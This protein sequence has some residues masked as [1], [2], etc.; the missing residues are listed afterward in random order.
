MEEL[1]EPIWK[2]PEA[3]PRGGGGWGWVDRKGGRHA[4]G[5]VERLAQAIAEDAGARVDMVWTPDS[6]YLVLPE[7]VRELWPALK[8]ARLKWAEWEMMEGMRQMKIFGVFI[9][10]FAIISYLG[11]G[12][13]SVMGT[14]GLAVILFLM[15]GFFPWYQGRKRWKRAK[16]WA[17]DEAEPDLEGLRF[18]VWLMSQ[19]APLTKALA[20]L[21][22]LV[23]L[24]QVLGPLSLAQQVEAAGLLKQDGRALDGWRLGTAAFLHGHP[25]HFLFNI[26]ALLYLGRRMEL[27]ARWPHVLL[28]FLLAAWV[29]NECSAR[30][31][32][33]P[34]L[35]ASG[36]LLGMLGFLLVFEWMHRRLVPESSRRRLLAGLLMTAAL[37][38]VGFK[39]VDNA[40][41]AG[42]TLA[43][44]VYAFAVFPRS[45][46][47]NR[48]RI[49]VVDGVA[50]V[51]AGTVVAGFGLLTIV[52]L[53]G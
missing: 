11:S 10:G 12:G 29:G 35:G 27:L 48:P 43:G 3:F 14:F 46:S 31:L 7:E 9:A 5:D 19:R 2:R 53:L 21:I 25:L 18:E 1:D 47:A 39:F 30:W 34:S 13:A 37:G 42:G 49:S 24:V 52:K 8:M 22:A 40:A 28:V 26:S 41:H 6:P 51:L 44:M 17:A 16:A 15:L 45:Q 20:G 36:G 23:A 32:P 4:C 50:G 33:G 38:V